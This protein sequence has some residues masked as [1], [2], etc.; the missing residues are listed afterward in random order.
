MEATEAA[1]PPPMSFA[2]VAT[3]L[4]VAS[5]IVRR[6]L[7]HMPPILCPQE[8]SQHDD[9]APTCPPSAGPFASPATALGPME[10]PSLTT[11]EKLPIDRRLS[12]RKYRPPLTMQV[13]RRR[14]TSHIAALP[15]ASSHATDVAATAESTTSTSWTSWFMSVC[16]SIAWDAVNAAVAVFVVVSIRYLYGSLH[17]LPSEEAY[18]SHL[19][20]K[21]THIFLRPSH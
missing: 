2:A 9:S 5:C 6:L 12:Y 20:R 17:G 11:S 7:A 3:A 4:V 13:V 18:L 10:C 19:H 16:W 8:S 15:D 1:L 14:Q 21:L